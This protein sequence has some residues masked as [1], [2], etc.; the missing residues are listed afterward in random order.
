MG[1]L[2][3]DRPDCVRIMCDRCILGQTKY[4]CWE[5]AEE[6]DEW[7]KSW[8][9]EM[10]AN[11]VESKVR[12]FMNTTNGFYKP[13]PMLTEDEIEDEFNRIMRYGKYRPDSCGD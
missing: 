9:R 4:I 5:C 10:R 1:V 3:C 6:L 13:Q 2:A 12:E 8:P 11:E 7:R